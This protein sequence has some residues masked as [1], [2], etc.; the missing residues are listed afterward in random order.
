MNLGYTTMPACEKYIVSSLQSFP[1]FNTAMEDCSHIYGDFAYAHRSVCIYVYLNV[2]MCV[3][4][5][6]HVHIYSRMCISMPVD[7]GVD[8]GCLP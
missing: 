7:E 1:P 5:R 8:V 2:C 3:R 4:V 6:V